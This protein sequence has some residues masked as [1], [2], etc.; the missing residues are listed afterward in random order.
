M[1]GAG[2]LEV[3]AAVAKEGVPVV[4]MPYINPVLSHDPRKFAA[5]A[6][7]AG[8][9]GG[10]V[11][12]PPIEEAEPVS[13]WLRSASLDTG[14][15]VAPTTQPDRIATICSHSSGFGYF[16]PLT[17]ITRGRQDLPAG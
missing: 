15:M 7:Q 4:L 1:T 13:G 3:G 11:P 9:A 2:A 17:G 10:I 16:V 8:V 5:E 6:S 12:D 14:F